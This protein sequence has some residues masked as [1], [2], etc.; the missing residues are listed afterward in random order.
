MPS[1]SHKIETCRAGHLKEESL[2][3]LQKFLNKIPAGN[4][5]AN[6]GRLLASFH[7]NSDQRTDK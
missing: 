6:A 1:P 4:T 3:F 7:I 5:R 2:S